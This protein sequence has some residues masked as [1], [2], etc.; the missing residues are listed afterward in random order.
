[1]F[2]SHQNPNFF[3]LQKI[4]FWVVFDKIEIIARKVLMLI[5]AFVIYKGYSV[6]K[7]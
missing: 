7:K 6:T 5:S 4:E 2:H 3:H 1:M